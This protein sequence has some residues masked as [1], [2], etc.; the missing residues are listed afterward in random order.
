MRF[1]LFIDN[2]GN[3]KNFKIK[4]F[5]M[6][7]KGKKHDFDYSYHGCISH[8]VFACLVK[9]V[10]TRVCTDWI[11]DF[12]SS[13]D[14]S[15]LFQKNNNTFDFNIARN[16]TRHN[17]NY[18]RICSTKNNDCLQKPFAILHTYTHNPLQI[19]EIIETIIMTVYFLLKLSNKNVSTD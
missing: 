15:I 16:L 7:M 19:L 13:I 10:I 4:D 6:E 9:L 3:A 18:L 17:R 5:C 8:T 12:A 2:L 11:L 1:T 14:H